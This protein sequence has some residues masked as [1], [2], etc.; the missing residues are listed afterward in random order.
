M[1]IK[2]LKELL[3]NYR[4]EQDIEL[5]SCAGVPYKILK[6]ESIVLASDY[7]HMDK[8]YLRIK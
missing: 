7:K 5:L 1:K 3:E 6:G 4:D 8:T 2:E